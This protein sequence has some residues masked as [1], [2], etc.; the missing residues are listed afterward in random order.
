MITELLK[1]VLLG[2]VQGITE[3]LPVSSTAHLLIV[4]QFLRS[5]LSANAKELFFVLIQLSSILAVVVL[6]FS[7]LWP[8]GAKKS[9]QAKKE[10]W[11]LWVKII[12]ATIPAGVAGFLLNDYMDSHLQRWTVIAS[13]LFCYGVLYI[14]LEKGPFGRVERRVKSLEAITIVDAFVLGLFQTLALVPG[15]SRSGST[16]LGGIMLGLDRAVSAQFSFFMAIPV[17]A[18]ASLLKLIKLGFSYTGSEW[19]I[20]AVG[21]VTSFVVSLVVVRAMIS[22]IKRHD[23]SAF[24]VY[25]I[26]LALAMSAYFLLAA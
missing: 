4:D 1:S 22:Y 6:Y 9:A 7:M 25:R 26:I 13:A 24:G 23:F 2:L 15:T 18:G 17:M 8:F 3:W 12:I 16:I 11:M 14:F 21:F 20:M 5:N 10:T 19:A